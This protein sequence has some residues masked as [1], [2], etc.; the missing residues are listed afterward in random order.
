MK[1]CWWMLSAKKMCVCNLER[2]LQLKQEPNDKACAGIKFA[3]VF[4]LKL[5][6][7][8]GSKE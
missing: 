5:I 1:M 3:C 4:M 6:D 7:S 8:V 2:M